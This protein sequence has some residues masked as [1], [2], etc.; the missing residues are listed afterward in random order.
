MD[1][2]VA[3]SPHRKILLVDDD[4]SLLRVLAIRLQRD[5]YDVQAAENGRRALAALPCFRP[6][7]VVTDMRMDG[8]N[9]HALFDAIREREPTMPVIVLTAH[10][11]IPDAVDATQRGVFSYMTKPFDKQQLVD[12]IE[13]ASSLF[14]QTEILP[15]DDSEWCREIVSHSSAMDR[16]LRE[17]WSVSRRTS[18][19]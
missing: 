11:T 18:A 16:L 17:A 13:R 3:R 9:G 8:M 6:H 1:T 5:G 2:N 7:V 10:G 19:C 15:T 12:T 4:P 14:G